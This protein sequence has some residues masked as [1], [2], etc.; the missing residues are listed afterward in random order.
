MRIAI[1]SKPFWPS[2]GGVEATTHIL[3]RSLREHQHIPTVITA[4]TLNGS[5]E[6]SDE[7]SIVRNATFFSLLKQFSA[8]DK[9]IINGGISVPAALAAWIFGKKLIVWHQ[10]AGPCIS[11]TPGVW[12][13]LRRALALKLLSYVSLHVGVSAECLASKKLPAS[14]ASVVIFNPISP[15]LE[16]AA[17]GL[18][19]VS[20]DIDVLFVGRL[21][22]GKGV[23]VLADALR[24]LDVDGNKITVYFAGVG[25]AA[26]RIE[27]VLK[28]CQNIQITFGGRLEFAE[29]AGIYSRS[30][31]LVVPSTTHTEGMPVVIAE[32]LGFGL[33]VVGSDQPV[34]V[35]AIADAGL[36]C[37]QG[38]SAYLADALRSLLN[39]NELRKRFSGAARNRAHLFSYELFS[40][41]VNRVLEP[42]LK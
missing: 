1:F 35:E 22:E 28:E 37:P 7:Y 41:K 26:G 12:G 34:I 40:Q 2:M 27:A 16:N 6:I 33:P 31:C 11:G 19:S 24:R 5:K 29:L 3:A 38:N 13:S 39:N 42:D 14:A 9:V 18:Q 21:I 25:P 4:T 36:I 15:E 20:K 23:L 8:A 30:R 10:M 17:S 32:A